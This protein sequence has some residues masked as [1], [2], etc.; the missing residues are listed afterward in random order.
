MDIKE[1]IDT[2]VKELNRHSYLYYVEE[3]PSLSDF[4]YDE[5]YRELKKLEDE[6]NNMQDY[7]QLW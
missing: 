2:L 3:N 7:M 6:I 4:E 5:M 1:R